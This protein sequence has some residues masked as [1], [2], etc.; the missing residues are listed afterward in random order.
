MPTIDRS[1]DP[2]QF[3]D[4]QNQKRPVTRRA[5]ESES[6][7]L[8]AAVASFDNATT[9][10]LTVARMLCFSTTP[11]SALSTSNVLADV[12]L[13]RDARAPVRGNQT[14]R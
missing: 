5:G 11:G 4:R 10:T 13:F 8:A 14:M 9:P 2:K 3:L 12:P 1:Y 7:K 6:E